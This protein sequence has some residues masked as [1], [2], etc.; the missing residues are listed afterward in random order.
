[1][2]ASHN[3]RGFRSAAYYQA[4]SADKNME[5]ANKPMHP[6]ALFY[7]SWLNLHQIG[8][9]AEDW[10]FHQNRTAYNTETHRGLFLVYD[11]NTRQLDRVIMPHD[12]FKTAV[13]P[14]CRENRMSTLSTHYK[15]LNYESRAIGGF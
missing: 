14:G 15:D 9:T 5:F 2:P 1:V 6:S 12:Q 7:T 11:I 10:K 8:S 4:N 3:I 13:Y